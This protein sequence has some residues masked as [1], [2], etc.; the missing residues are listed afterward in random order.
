M[1]RPLILR[2]EKGRLPAAATKEASRILKTG[3][4]VLFPTDTVYGLGVNALDP[5]ARRKLY[6]LKGRAPSKP[7]PVLVESLSAASHLAQFGLSARALARAFWPGSLTLVLK[8]TAVGRRAA[9]G[10]DTIGLRVPDPPGLR[11]ILK[12]AGV[13]MAATSANRSGCPEC[14]DVPDALRQFRGRLDLILDD[15]ARRGKPSSVVDLAGEGPVLLRAGKL[16]WRKIRS[17][18][19]M[20]NTRA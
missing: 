18:L 16:S 3:G 17:V 7:L 11:R 2:L 5:A 6:A 1:K 15:G 13:P 12:A 8:A 20:K 19:R 14:Q 4:L 9:G 10:S